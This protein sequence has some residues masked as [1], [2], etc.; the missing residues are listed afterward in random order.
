MS[1]ELSNEIRSC[2]LPLFRYEVGS[3]DIY[4]SGDHD[5][6]M[7]M[8]WIRNEDMRPKTFPIDSFKVGRKEE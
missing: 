5:D 4:G 2:L 6:S 8:W 7:L 3:C 1:F